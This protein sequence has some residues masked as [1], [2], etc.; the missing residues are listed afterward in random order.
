MV[1]PE[2][3]ERQCRGLLV[4]LSICDA[5]LRDKGD[6]LTFAL[7]AT[8]EAAVEQQ[9][10]S[11]PHMPWLVADTQPTSSSPHTTS[12]TREQESRQQQNTSPTLVASQT[13]EI[14]DD[15]DDDDKD[16]CT[17]VDVSSGDDA[18]RA[19]DSSDTKDR[20]AHHGHADVEQ[21]TLVFSQG[22][23]DV[24]VMRR[25]STGTTSSYSSTKRAKA[26]QAHHPHMHTALSQSPTQSPPPQLPPQRTQINKEGSTNGQHKW[27][28]KQHMITSERP[29]LL[30]V[31]KRV[32]APP[33]TILVYAEESPL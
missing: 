11:R 12:E 28:H 18:G 15:D 22:S 30:H 19:S 20:N 10:A 3:L 32:C 16:D 33:L 13:V 8:T 23:A 6:Q 14:D 7:F 29:P 5:V 26:R 9:A 31:L 4:K 17:D 24:E 25:D 21:G 27:Q 2:E 1:E